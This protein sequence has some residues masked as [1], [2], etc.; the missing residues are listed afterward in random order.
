MNYGETPIAG[1]S[2]LCIRPCFLTGSS[3]AWFLLWIEILVLVPYTVG[4]TLQNIIKS[5]I[6]QMWSH[7]LIKSLKFS[8]G[9]YSLRQLDTSLCQVDNKVNND[10]IIID[11]SYKHVMVKTG[12]EWRWDEG[13]RNGRLW[14]RGNWNCYVKQIVLKIK[15]RIAEN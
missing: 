5:K 3:L 1:F 6:I 9:D 14:G 13:G 2:L 8:K 4:W 11:Q 7:R 15:N 10:V 12:W